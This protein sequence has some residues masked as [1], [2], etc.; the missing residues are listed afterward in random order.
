MAD[1][2]GILVT[3]NCLVLGRRVLRQT[4]DLRHTF[5]ALESLD[6]GESLACPA[7]PEDGGGAYRALAR[8]RRSTVLEGYLFGVID[9][10]MGTALEAIRLHGRVLP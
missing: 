1:C 10:C 9:V 8:G 6:N 4:P 7:N 3:A 5:T 2:D